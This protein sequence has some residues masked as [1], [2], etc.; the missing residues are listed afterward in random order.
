[1]LKLSLE[2]TEEPIPL[3]R[4]AV[5]ALQG[6]RVWVVDDDADVRVMMKTILERKGAQ[7]TVLAA[8]GE[9]LKM[10][11]EFRPEV[12][13]CDIGMPV[14]DGYMLM[15][16]VRTRGAERGGEVP[17]IALT[18]YATLEDSKRALA[19]GYQTYLAKPV[20]PEELVRSIAKLAGSRA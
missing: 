12:L 10:L 13:V 4:A 8:A 16:E 6:M 7:V 3:S 1:L 11:D 18:G 5:S 2:P 15:R 9:A 19:V 20:E 17:A 14:M